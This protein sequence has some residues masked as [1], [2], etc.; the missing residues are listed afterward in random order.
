MFNYQRFILCDIASNHRQRLLQNTVLSAGT[1]WYLGADHTIGDD[2][3]TLP[4]G[5]N[6][7]QTPLTRG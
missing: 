1:S 3:G 6:Q 2:G 7:T 4:F 5:T